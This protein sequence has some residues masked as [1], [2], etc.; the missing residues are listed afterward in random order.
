M[1]SQPSLET[2]RQILAVNSATVTPRSAFTVQR[3]E[4]LAPETVLQ[5]QPST[6]DLFGAASPFAFSTV[7]KKPEGPQ[8][9]NLRFALSPSDGALK[10][11][12]VAKSPTPTADRI[13]L[14]DKNITASFWSFITDK[15][16][17]GSQ[18]SFGD[19]SKGALNDVG[20]SALNMDMSLGDVGTTGSLDFTDG[21]LRSID[22]S[23][24]A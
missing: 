13:P 19:R 7:K 11:D 24:I 3:D 1:D 16:S 15:A 18:G 10:G 4:T 22:D 6:Q 9:S 12:A 8:R 21:F 17:Q 2:P 23:G 5:A 14:K 20:Y